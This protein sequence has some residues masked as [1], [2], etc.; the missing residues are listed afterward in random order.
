MEVASVVSGERFGQHHRRYLWRPDSATTKLRETCSLSGQGADPTA[1][2]YEI[3]ALR[4]RL[5]DRFAGAASTRSAQVAAA[6]ASSGPTGPS[7]ASSWA[8]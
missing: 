1:V 3:H 8:R 7:S 6:K 4:R 2:E 5:L